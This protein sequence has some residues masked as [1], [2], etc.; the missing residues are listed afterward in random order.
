MYVPDPPICWEQKVIFYITTPIQAVVAIMYL[1]L[2]PLYAFLAIFKLPLMALTLLMTAVWIPIVG[3]ILGCGKV[4][5]AFPAL[6]PISFLVAFPFLVVGHILVT[7]EPLP[8]PGDQEG[9]LTKLLLI[10][11]FPFLPW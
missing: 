10:E 1:L 11:K 7:L 2:T 8:T 4:S 3:V 9:K 6:R 5:R